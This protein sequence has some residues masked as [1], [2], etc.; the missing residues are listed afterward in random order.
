MADTYSKEAITTIGAR[1]LFGFETVAGT[2]PT[3]MADYTDFVGITSIPDLSTAADKLETTDLSNTRNKTYTKGLT[4]YGDIEFG[5]HL[6]D[7]LYHQ[8]WDET[9]GIMAKYAIAEA[10]GKKMWI[11]ID[12]QGL[13][14]S[15][16]VPV[17]PQDLIPSGGD[18]NSV[19]DSK[20][21]F[22]VSGDIVPNGADPTEA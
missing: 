22:T 13:S 3:A 1:V 10:A 14:N 5:V 12:Y 9:T 15:V 18:V 6:S 8:Y 21:R 2:R 19:V 17:V 16:Y 11:C 4:D 20:L 7:A